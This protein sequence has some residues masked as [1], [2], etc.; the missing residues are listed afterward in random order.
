M[1]KSKM[2][3]IRKQVKKAETILLSY[4]PYNIDVDED[5]Y[6]HVYDDF[7]ENMKYLKIKGSKY[8]LQGENMNWRGSSAYAVKDKWHDVIMSLFMH[9]GQCTIDIYQGDERNTLDAIVYHHDCPTGS[10]ITIMSEHKAIKKGILKYYA[11]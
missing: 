11:I 1:E 3:E 7:I 5:D 2:K 4:D 9:N 10:R 8:Y 6:C